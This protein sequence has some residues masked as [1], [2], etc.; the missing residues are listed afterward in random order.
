MGFCC[1]SRGESIFICLY[2]AYVSVLYHIIHAVNG[3]FYLN[4]LNMCCVLNIVMIICETNHVVLWPH[5]C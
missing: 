3:W 2:N 1:F 4:L 5:P